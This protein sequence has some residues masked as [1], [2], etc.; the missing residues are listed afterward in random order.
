M[1][2]RFALFRFVDKAGKRYT[3]KRE[4]LADTI[5]ESEAWDKPEIRKRVDEL[6]PGKSITIA[7]ETLTRIDGTRK[8]N[9]K[10]CAPPAVAGDTVKPRASNPI[11]DLPPKAARMHDETYRSMRE[12]G[13]D[14]QTASRGAWC[15]VDRFYYRGAGERW[16][17]RKKPLAAV[18]DEPCP[19]PSQAKKKRTRKKNAGGDRSPVA[20]DDLREA[21]EHGHVIDL[22]IDEGERTR[23][24]KFRRAPP[25]LL[26][27]P[28]ARAVVWWH[29]PRTPAKRDHDDGRSS[30]ARASFERFHGRQPDADRELATPSISGRWRKLG[31]AVQIGY[32]NH[33]KWGEP[34]EH[35]FTS[36][37][38]VYRIGGEQP[39]TLWVL[40]GGKLRMT[41]DGIEG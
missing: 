21:S 18:G 41:P 28:R 16:R 34:A 36:S 23:R 6:A 37:V 13:H 19:S 31:T 10:K 20:L 25:L 29:G 15:T 9:A 33:E 12:A 24:Y 7:G 8:K 3:W 22:T 2:S 30:R 32:R 40:V 27:S 38:R 5:F 14:E 26:W 39:P 17:R 35:D 11:G 4:V 1:P